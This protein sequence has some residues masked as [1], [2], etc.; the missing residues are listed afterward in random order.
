MANRPKTKITNRRNGANLNINRHKLDNTI[1]KKWVEKAIE[2][3][4][5]GYSN[6][7]VREHIMTNKEGAKTEGAVRSIMDAANVIINNS[8]FQ[9]TEE[10]MPLHLS[11]YNSLIK[12]LKA[13][14]DI[15]EDQVDGEIVTWKDFYRKREEKIKAYENC[16]TT[17]FQREK[18]LKFHNKDFLF[19]WTKEEV[20][21]VKEVEKKITIT[22][23]E[24]AEQIEL[25]NLIKKTRKDENDLG[26]IIAGQIEA[27]AEVVDI[28]HEVVEQPNIEQIKHLQLPEPPSSVKTT[29]HDPTAKLRESLA[30]LAA[31][32]FKEIGKL[33]EDEEQ[34]IK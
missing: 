32:K 34:L 20:V 25:L 33:T 8:Q 6:L 11:R 1:A 24:L 17:L 22:K 7:Y 26:A 4:K 9:K 2:L 27:K 21:E 31:G 14:K 28:E 19:K 15:S 3:F 13:T 23:L 30:K 16:I 29:Y 10:M 5:Q 12:A 18:L